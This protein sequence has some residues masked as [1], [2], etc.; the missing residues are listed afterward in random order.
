MK[1]EIFVIKSSFKNPPPPPVEWIK[2]IGIKSSRVVNSRSLSS[3]FFREEK[4][5]EQHKKRGKICVVILLSGGRNF[6]S[7]H[8]FGRLVQG[9]A[10]KELNSGVLLSALCS[11]LH[12]EEEK[13]YFLNIR[14]ASLA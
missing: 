9:E 11:K 5:D 4:E 2:R 3:S 8:F 13:K 7:N 12:R 14:N 6:M 1:E 10:E